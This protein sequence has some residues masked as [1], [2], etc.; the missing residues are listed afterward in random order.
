MGSDGRCTRGCALGVRAVD[1]RS[2]KNKLSASIRLTASGETMLVS[3]R[4]R[5]VAELV[6]PRAGQAESLDDADLADA[7]R[8]GWLT[9]RVYPRG[10]VPPSLPVAPLERILTDTTR[11]NGDTIHV[12][13]LGESPRSWRARGRFLEL[14]RRVQRRRECGTT[15]TQLAVVAFPLASSTT[16]TSP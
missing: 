16:A 9:P 2:L 7:V 12:A 4:D 3:N 1:I 6:P 13:L 15:T 14:V 11:P 10:A 8:Q 5:I